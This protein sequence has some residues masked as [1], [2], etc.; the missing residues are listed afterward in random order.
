M[1]DAVDAVISPLIIG[2]GTVDDVTIE[3]YILTSGYQRF[4]GAHRISQEQLVRRRP[5]NT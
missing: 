2:G 4:E 5:Q 3:G 1:R